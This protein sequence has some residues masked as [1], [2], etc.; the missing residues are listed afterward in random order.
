MAPQNA[1]AVDVLEM[2]TNKT[3]VS[4][5]FIP[6]PGVLGVSIV[7]GLFMTTMTNLGDY[8]GVISIAQQLTVILG[9]WPVETC[10]SGK[11]W[12]GHKAHNIQTMYY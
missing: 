9:E 6:A 10:I 4:R 3:L 1:G 8:D 12:G 11:H 5:V 2:G 7:Q